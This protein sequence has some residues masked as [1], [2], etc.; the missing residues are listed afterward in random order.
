[1]FLKPETEKECD[2]GE[3]CNYHINWVK[4]YKS[5]INKINTKISP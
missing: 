3:G 4:K 2:I 5:N 1:M